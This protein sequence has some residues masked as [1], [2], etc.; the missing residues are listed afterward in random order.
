MN[1][2]A[3]P[4]KVDWRKTASTTDADP[5]DEALNQTPPD[6]VAILGFDPAEY[7]RATKLQQHNQKG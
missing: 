5:D 1:S 7:A 6:V 2:I 4:K 3:K